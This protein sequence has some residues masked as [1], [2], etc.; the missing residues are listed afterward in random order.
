M[1]V[2][3]RIPFKELRIKI[4]TQDHFCLE[5]SVYMRHLDRNTAIQVG[6]LNEVSFL[7]LF[8]KYKCS[9]FSD[10]VFAS[11]FTLT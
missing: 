4:R 8:N 11:R 5:P 7:L 9:I 1:Y 3:L 10:N 2:K 6:F